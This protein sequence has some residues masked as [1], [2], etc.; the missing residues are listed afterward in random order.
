MSRPASA[1]ITILN[2]SPLAAWIVNNRTAPP[3]SSSATASSSFAPSILLAHESNEAG[4][5][6]TANRLVVPREAPEL[7]QIGEATAAVPTGQDGQV[8]VVLADDPLTES[9]ESHAGRCAHES[10]VPLEEGAKQALVAGG[11]VLGK[12]SLERREKRS[13]RRVSPDEHERVVGHTDEGRCKDGRER[14]VV[15]A[16]VEQP[17]IGEKVDDLLLAEVAAPGRAIRREAFAPKGLLVAFGVGPGGEEDDDLSRIGL[18]ESTSSRTRLAIRR[19]SPWR[20]CSPVRRS[21]S[22]R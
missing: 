6:C 21:S 9:L 15:V 5:V 12:R 17:E 4:D 11:Q 13:A 7:A 20:Q 18:V 14:H 8:V 19:A 2:S 1:T 22:C 3:P 10:L 16:V